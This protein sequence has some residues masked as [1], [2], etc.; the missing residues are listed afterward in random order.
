MTVWTPQR[1]GLLNQRFSEA[2]PPAESKPRRLTQMRDL[3]RRFSATFYRAEPEEA[4]PLR[5]L[6]TPIYRFAAE[7]DGIVDGALFSLA[8][9][10]DPD[11]LLLVE[12]VRDGADSPAYWRYSVARM[13]SAKLAV[14]LDGR[15]VVSLGNYHRD[16][17][18]A[19]KTGPYMEQRIGTFV[20]AVG[21]A[22]ETAK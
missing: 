1:Y 20:P 16:T 14:W 3:A 15:E 10:T 7:A 19:K 8:N 2:S 12:A 21:A 9:A 6:T 22:A 5:L 4:T 11:V 18:E 13:T 17:P